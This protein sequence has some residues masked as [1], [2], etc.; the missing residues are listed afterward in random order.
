MKNLLLNKIR[1]SWYLITFLLIYLVLV[2][3]LPR[4]KF[5]AG[6]L[7]LFSVN[8]FLYGFYIAPIL[9]GQKARIEELHRIARS[10]T[11]A[12]FDIMLRV[13]KLPA[14]AKSE[15][16]ALFKS[17][18]QL[19]LKHGSGKQ[20]EEKYEE[21]ISYCLAYK[22]DAADKM[23]GILDKVVANQQNRTMMSMQ[24]RNSV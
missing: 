2:H 18:I 24:L 10:E 6:A 1:L 19:Q 5:D 11:N 3:Y 15:L 9:G 14:K 4:E 13:K 21:I 7:T 22:G 12:L 8:S 16:G 20:S 17:Y 23:T